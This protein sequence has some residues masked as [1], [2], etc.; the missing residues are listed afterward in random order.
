MRLCFYNHAPEFSKVSDICFLLLWICRCMWF[1]R[2]CSARLSVLLN[3]TA[4]LGL[5]V[6]IIFKFVGYF[7]ICKYFCLLIFRLV[8]MFQRHLWERMSASLIWTSSLVPNCTKQIGWIWLRAGL[9][10]MSNVRKYGAQWQKSS[11]LNTWRKKIARKSR[12]KSEFFSLKCLSIRNFLKW[13]IYLI[14]ILFIFFVAIGSC[15]QYMY[16]STIM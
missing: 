2:I 5:L 12:S 16:P 11:L 14:F 3:L 4:N 6:C 8:C 15:H 10:Q 9:L 7:A 13:L 1:L